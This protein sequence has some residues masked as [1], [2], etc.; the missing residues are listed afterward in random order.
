[1][2]TL[3]LPLRRPLGFLTLCLWLGCLCWLALA[4]SRP[5]EPRPLAAPA[6]EF[7]AERAALTVNRLAR[8][9]RPIGSIENQ[10]ALLF[11]QS[12]LDK[13]GWET[14]VQRQ[15]SALAHRGAVNAGHVANL[16]ARKK[17]AAPVS[18]RSAVMLSA[19]YD[20]VPTGPGAADDAASVA[21][22]IE[23]ARALSASPALKNDVLLVITDGEEAGL[24][25]AAAFAKAHPWAL[26]VAL[27]LNF[28]F[29]GNAGAMTLFET[30]PGNAALIQGVARAAPNAVGS[31][32]N[33]EIYKRLSND[34]DMSAFKGQ[35]IGG[36]NF[37]AI[38]GHSSYH[39][40]ADSAQALD[41]RSLQ[42]E[43]E[44]MLSLA[45]HFA[46]APALRA[47]SP[48]DAIYFNLPGAG[49]IAYSPAAGWALALA[50][51]AL[52]ARA[53]QLARAAGGQLSDA[54]GSAW[55]HARLAAG[56]VI[57]SQAAWSAISYLKTGFWSGFRG[58]PPGS[59]WYL[60]SF[61]SLAA[62]LTLWALSRRS[63]ALT[64]PRRAMGALGALGI[65]L[66]GLLWVMTQAPG[67]SFVIALPALGALIALAIALRSGSADSAKSSLVLWLGVAPAILILIP[68]ARGVLIG[69]SPSFI[70]APILI[71]FLLLIFLCAPIALTRSPERLALGSLVALGSL[72]LAWA[73]SV[74]HASPANPRPTH[75]FYAQEGARSRWLSN[76]EGVSG[77]RASAMSAPRRV[78]SPGFFGARAGAFWE[79]PAP[80][81][82]LAAPS[83]AVLSDATQEDARLVSVWVS[84][85]R[86]AR[87][88]LVELN[89]ALALSAK[90]NQ[91]ETINAPETRWAA[92]VFNAPDG[93]RLDF[94]LR[95]G[96]PFSL[97]AVDRSFGLPA[98][99]P[100]MPSEETL[101][102]GFSSSSS[103]SAAERSFP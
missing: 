48:K 89:G 90:I 4:S 11:L 78:Q 32:F 83:I 86:G 73:L 21:A 57:G 36:L 25:G 79:S 93:V 23:T 19:H 26:D 47:R 22:L 15:F 14:R 50:C 76:D 74:D 6:S 103:Q 94:K 95:P 42:H 35:G 33:Y 102:P 40:A 45:R 28:E 43:G 81:A 27:A 31:S 71:F 2:T 98:A 63:R 30:S 67:A 60:A 75:L 85:E 29:R 92:R 12:E 66:I 49:F 38:E 69:L 9:P 87:D 34:T 88:F 53:F 3:P 44:L 37:A 91:L 13:L 70:G 84:S 54:L 20:S 41:R 99:L 100:P 10:Q 7:S 82:Q 65:A 68:L 97:R 72:A 51:L 61:C 52:W 59:S 62:A 55:L 39:T 1:M 101:A 56:L 58:E 80:N 17:G 8:A 18:S 5:P 16:I 64:P 77:W 96:A 46:N 24:L